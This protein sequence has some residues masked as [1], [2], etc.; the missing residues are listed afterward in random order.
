MLGVFLLGVF[1]L[2]DILKSKGNTEVQALEQI[3][4][5]KPNQFCGSVHTRE[6]PRLTWMDTTLQA[7]RE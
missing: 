2:E 6:M 1:L 5:M 7:R 3:C 4:W